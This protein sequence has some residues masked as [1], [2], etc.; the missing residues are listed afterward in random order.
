MKTVYKVL[1]IL[2]V[3]T[4]ILTVLGSIDYDQSFIIQTINT[5]QGY[6]PNFSEEELLEIL[7]TFNEVNSFLKTHPDAHHVITVKVGH[8]QVHYSASADVGQVT[9]VATIFGEKVRFTHICEEPDKSPVIKSYPSIFDIEDSS[10]GWKN[11]D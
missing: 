11:E 5:V 1:V 9:L 2:V 6:E 4:A 8:Q 7:G 3:I 10:C